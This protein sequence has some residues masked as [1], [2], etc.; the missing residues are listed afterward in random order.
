MA[1]ANKMI[2]KKTNSYFT[3]NNILLLVCDL[4]CIK[5]HAIYVL[6]TEKHLIYIVI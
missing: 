3:G 2:S 6:L 4:H 1:I 5:N